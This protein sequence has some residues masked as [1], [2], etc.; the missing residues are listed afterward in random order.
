LDERYHAFEQMPLKLQHNEMQ[1]L[2]G[3]SG[4][5]IDETELK[6]TAAKPLG[7]KLIDGHSCH[8]YEARTKY[9][10]AYKVWLGDD[11]HFLVRAELAGGKIITLKSWSTAIPSPDLFKIPAGYS[12]SVR[13]G[14]VSRKEMIACCERKQ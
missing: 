5:I 8:G 4:I 14:C 2:F 1:G 7:V 13:G 9:D 3:L 6:K 12:E 10:E 11:I